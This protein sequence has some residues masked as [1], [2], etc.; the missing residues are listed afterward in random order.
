MDVGDTFQPE[1]STLMIELYS[2][3][4]PKDISYMIVRYVMAIPKY[5]LK[6]IGS[7]H[8]RNYEDKILSIYACCQNKIICDLC[9]N[10]RYQDF[11]DYQDCVIDLDTR[12]CSRITNV[13]SNVYNNTFLVMKEKYC[14]ETKIDL[15]EY[16]DQKSLVSVKHTLGEMACFWNSVM[17]V[18]DG[19]NIY[20]MTKRTENYN[21]SMYDIKNGGFNKSG[22]F[23]K[24]NE[25]FLDDKIMMDE[26]LIVQDGDTLYIHDKNTL[27]IIKTHTKVEI[28]KQKRKYC[29]CSNIIYVI[30]IG[31]IE[32]YDLL[33]LNHLWDISLKNTITNI[34]NVTGC[35]GKI[36]ILTEN[37]YHIINIQY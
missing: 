24:S 30:Y 9:T 11:Y 21:L 2:I 23:D 29:V 20:H 26:Y 17:S 32:A 31:K 10:H 22:T 19:K 34:R 28:I 25:K 14:D 8:I 5:E 4:L 6:Y 15:M 33:T 27:E 36:I 18:H 3:F 37:D 16:S 7:S 12:Q 35:D 1:L 13:I